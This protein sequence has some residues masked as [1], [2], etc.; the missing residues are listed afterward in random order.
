MKDPFGVIPDDI[1]TQCVNDDKEF[2][3]YLRQVK[4]KEDKNHF[5][6]I[7]LKHGLDDSLKWEILEYIEMQDDPNL[8][9]YLRQGEIVE[10]EA[11][12]KNYFVYRH[13]DKND[14]LLYIGISNAPFVRLKAHQKK[15]V[16]IDELM[17]GGHTTYEPHESKA[18]AHR[19]EAEAIQREHPR[20]NKHH[21]GN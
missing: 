18:E 15:S 2:M 10:A 19:A 16:W 8:T 11:T 4:N 14:V 17:D 12:V 13:F 21:N 1:Y 5:Y 6:S 3:G 9:P 20:Y 7:Y